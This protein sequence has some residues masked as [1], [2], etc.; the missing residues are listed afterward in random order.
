MNGRAGIQIQVIA[1]LATACCSYLYTTRP[2]PGVQI[3]PTAVTRRL[4]KSP[5]HLYHLTITPPT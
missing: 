1:V 5:L 4:G 2:D 3:S